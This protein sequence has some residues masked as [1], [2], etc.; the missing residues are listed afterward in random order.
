[1]R[2]IKISVIFFLLIISCACTSVDQR[3]EIVANK[4]DPSSYDTT[5]F[6]YITCSR[7]TETTQGEEITMKYEVYY[8][9]N[10]VVQVLKSYEKVESSDSSILSQYEKAYQTI[11]SSYQNLDYYENEITTTGRSVTSITYINY[12]KVNMKKLMEIEG[13]E[14][15]VKVTNGKIKLAD[16]KSFAKKYG[17]VCKN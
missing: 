11:Y 12:G 6:D 16:W 15:N 10:K 4:I 17:T 8:D 3:S 7:D 1:M 13:S 9:K 5:D 2:K 14:D